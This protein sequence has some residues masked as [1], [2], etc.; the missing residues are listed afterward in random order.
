MNFDF[1][2]PELITAVAGAATA[3]AAGIVAVISARK[4]FKFEKA[5]EAAK[6]R[7]TYCICPHCKKKISLSEIHWIL[8]TGEIDDNLNGKP[9]SLE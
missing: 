4:S 9:D 6:Q 8:P 5:L 3:I 7:D 2:T 1:L